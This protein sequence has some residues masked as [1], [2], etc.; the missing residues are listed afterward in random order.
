MSSHFDLRCGH[1]LTLL[2]QTPDESVNCVVTSPPYWGLRDYG[3]EPQIWGGSDGCCH[4]WGARHT[5]RDIRE[6]TI[7]GKTRTTDRFY[8]DESRRFNGN[9]QKITDGQFCQLCGAWFGS[10][11]LEPTYQLYIEHMVDVFREI[12]RVLKPDGTAWLNL[13]DC[14][15]TGAGKVGDCPGGG[16]QGERWAGYRGSRPES[17]LHSEGA[18]GPMT[19]P[20]RMPQVGLKP[21]DLC[22]IPHRTAIA[23]QEDGWW[24]RM[25]VVWNKPNP[26]PESVTDRPTKAHEYIFLLSKQ[27]KY[28][29]D[30]E[31]IK[32][33]AICGWNGSSF[34]DTRDLHLY[35][36]IGKKPRPSA[37]KG[38]FEG[39]T[40][41]MADTGQNAFRAVVET[42]NKRSVWTLSTTPTP[43]A[44]FATFPVDLAET[45]ILASCPGDGLVL[46]PFNGA[47]TTGLAA[48]K[49]GRR[50]IGL[51]LNPEYINISRQRARK[52]YPLLIGSEGDAA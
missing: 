25:D 6:D 26:M 24:V 23:L 17:P 22:M 7:S 48:L 41:A 12:R 13:G 16:Q 31:A 32:E 34:D 30:H 44:H 37:A 50:Y 15:A 28:Y 47:A 3:T 29:Y 46:D 21:K 1:V 5:V 52:Y 39:K 42:R 4:E 36:N 10:F 14:F 45:C 11:G 33:P 43:E 9:H 20:N 35:P 40:E 38:T 51:E 49:H 8:G 19:Q 27:E 2:K 18:I